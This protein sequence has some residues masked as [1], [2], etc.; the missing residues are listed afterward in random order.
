MFV[1]KCGLIKIYYSFYVCVHVNMCM[2]SFY[3]ASTSHKP[4]RK[5]RQLSPSHTEF[6][7]Y[8][9]NLL[10]LIRI[11]QIFF[12]VLIYGCFLQVAQVNLNERKLLN[13]VF[14]SQIVIITMGKKWQIAL[15]GDALSA[16]NN[17]L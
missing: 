1:L 9:Y 11:I 7:M 14:D 17:W 5:Q 16:L 12:V 10:L 2:F 8:P 13:L 3:F 6:Q 4:S 15:A